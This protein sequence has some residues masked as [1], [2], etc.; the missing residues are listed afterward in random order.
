M[1]TINKCMAPWTVTTTVQQQL[2]TAST[3]TPCWPSAGLI[4]Q[5]KGRILP[6]TWLIKNMHYATLPALRILRASQLHQTDT[7]GTQLHCARHG[8]FTAL[9]LV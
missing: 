5:S 8:P 2:C 1:Q 7:I 3:N 4:L 9:L 6:V